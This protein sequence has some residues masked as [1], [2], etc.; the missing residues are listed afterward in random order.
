MQAYGLRV[1]HNVIAVSVNADDRRQS[2]TNVGEGRDFP[3]HIRHILL[4]SQPRNRIRL[5]VLACEQIV[6]VADPVPIYD[7]SHFQWHVSPCGICW[8]SA[9]QTPAGVEHSQHECEMTTCRMAGNDDVI[10]IY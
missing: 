6:Y 5:A 4:I 10:D 7:R 8:T 1:R 2:W 9:V 3:G